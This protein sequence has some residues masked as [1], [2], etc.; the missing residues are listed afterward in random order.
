MER[1]PSLSDGFVL[2]RTG[3]N[4]A[5]Y[6][7]YRDEADSLRLDLRG[8][9]GE[10]RAVAVDT[11]R[12]YEEIDLGALPPREQTWQAPNRSDWA[13]AVGEFPSGAK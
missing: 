11:R 8:M 1:A 10:Q 7:F 9:G 3:K 2:A 5:Q 13:I 12:P 4:G 6:I